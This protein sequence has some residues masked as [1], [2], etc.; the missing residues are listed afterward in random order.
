MGGRGEKNLSGKWCLPQGGGEERKV[1]SLAS[2]A[3]P[4]V[5]G[6]QKG[7]GCE[8]WTKLPTPAILKKSASC[9]TLMCNMSLNAGTLMYV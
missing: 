5:D 4:R 9:K 1:L 7:G 2:S 3:C 6:G 8:Q